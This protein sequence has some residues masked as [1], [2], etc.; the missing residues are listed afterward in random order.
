MADETPNPS[1]MTVRIEAVVREH[2]GYI[3]ATLVGQV[4][5]LQVAE[6]IHQKQGLDANL[7]IDRWV[8]EMSQAIGDPKRLHGNLM[9]LIERLFGDDYVAAAE[10]RLAARRAALGLDPPT[11]RSAPGAG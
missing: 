3:L 2:W 4:R 1:R 8:D 11:T 7:L 10:E 6:E 5:D 9:V